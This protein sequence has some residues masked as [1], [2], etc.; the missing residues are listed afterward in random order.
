MIRVNNLDE[1]LHFTLRF[2]MKLL[3]RQDYESGSLTLALSA[4]A[5]SPTPR[6]VELTRSWDTDKYELGNAF[7]HVALG[8]PDIYATCEA[9]LRRRRQDS[10][11]AR[12]DEAR[13]HRHRVRRRS[14]RF[15]LSHPDQVLG[16]SLWASSAGAARLV[17]LDDRG[18]SVTD[19]VH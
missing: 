8:T 6:S 7:G 15:G 2:G 3:R 18:L 14:E 13:H 5:K 1:S 9:I 10:P 11:R 19:I 4:T 17:K 16:P 12:T